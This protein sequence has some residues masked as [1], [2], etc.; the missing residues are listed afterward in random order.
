[1][2]ARAKKSTNRAA[3]I[4]RPWFEAQMRRTGTTTTKLSEELIGHPSLLGRSLRGEREFNVAELCG[5]AKAFGVPLNDIVQRLGHLPPRA[6]ISV[7]GHVLA[8][9]RI[10]KPEGNKKRSVDAPPEMSANAEALDVAELTGER[11]LPAGATVY[12]EPSDVLLPDAFYRL[13]VVVLGD[14][15]NALLGVLERGRIGT[16]R[17]SLPTHETIDSGQLV[18][19]TPVRWLRF[20]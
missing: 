2:Q 5:L 10:V 18:S 8:D 4:D 1:M 6:K 14:Q 3:P 7:V 13:S 15:P 16:V 11:F 19:A 12:Y 9:G 20:G 17:V